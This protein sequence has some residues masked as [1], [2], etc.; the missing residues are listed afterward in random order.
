[1]SEPPFIEYYFD[2]DS[3]IPEEEGPP[4]RL[5]L[6][7]NLADIATYIESLIYP[8]TKLLG[9][10]NQKPVFVSLTGRVPQTAQD[11]AGGIRGSCQFWPEGH[12]GIPTYCIGTIMGT[13]TAILASEVGRMFAFTP[14]IAYGPAWEMMEGH[15]AAEVFVNVEG[16]IQLRFLKSMAFRTVNRYIRYES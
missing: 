5:S 11:L 10:L 6:P 16:I 8:E 4:Q 2:S 13:R 3:T 14:F 1:M 12:S 15:T 9:T 7:T